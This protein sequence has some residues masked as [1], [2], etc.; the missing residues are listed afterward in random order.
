MMM[1]IRWEWVEDSDGDIDGR[2]PTFLS[3]PL[4]D[5]SSMLFLLCAILGSL[6]ELELGR[7]ELTP[8]PS[9]FPDPRGGR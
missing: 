9:F 4:L 8:R 5:L 1:V 7:E 2:Q 6:S 3:R